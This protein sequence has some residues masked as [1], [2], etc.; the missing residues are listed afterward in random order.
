M[1]YATNDAEQI[2]NIFNTLADDAW[3]QLGSRPF[4][5]LKLSEIAAH[6]EVNA[7]LAVAVAA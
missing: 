7:A 4:A 6:A 1:T 2:A 5:D 3:Q